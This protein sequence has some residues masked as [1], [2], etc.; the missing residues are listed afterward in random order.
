MLKLMNFIGFKTNQRFMINNDKYNMTNK[1]M[2]PY[3]DI[4]NKEILS[5]IHDLVIDNI[6]R[7]F[8][9]DMIQSL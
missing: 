5:I 4:V 1:K 8:S 2:I 6:L 9:N 3:K 7:K